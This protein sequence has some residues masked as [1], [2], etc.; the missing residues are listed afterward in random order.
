MTSEGM[1]T[2]TLS[3]LLSAPGIAALAVLGIIVLAMSRLFGA[4]TILKEVVTEVVASFGNAI[5]ILALF[6]LFFRTGFEHL[7]RRAPGGDAIAESAERLREMLQDVNEG[8]QDKQEPP[9]EE[10]LTRIDEGIRSLIDEDIPA[11][12][13]EIEALRRLVSSESGGE[14]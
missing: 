2:P 9:Y 14:H 7:L 10:K 4:D 6:T 11:L 5:L 13:T 1:Q 12:K 8:G 3:R